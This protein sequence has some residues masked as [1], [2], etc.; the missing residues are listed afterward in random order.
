MNPAGLD[1]L[2][3]RP[4]GPVY[5][6][7]VARTI[8][9]TE[10]IATATGPRITTFLVNNRSTDYDAGPSSLKGTLTYHSHYATAVMKGTGIYGPTGQP[11]RPKKGKYLVFTGA[12]GN[13]VFA[14][15][16]KG[17]Q[18]NPFLANAFRAGAAPWPV[19]IH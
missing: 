13:T 2:L 12:D 5:D 16:V 19:T 10:A 18:G 17:Q 14:R 1:R 7:V 11:I 4:G 8:E 15:S 6:R 3:R 9:R